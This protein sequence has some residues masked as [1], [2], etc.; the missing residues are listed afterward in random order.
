[1]RWFPFLVVSFYP[2]VYFT[3]TT[4]HSL[5]EP[6]SSALNPVWLMSAAPAGQ[7]SLST[8]GRGSVHTAYWKLFSTDQRFGPQGH[9]AGGAV[10]KGVR[11]S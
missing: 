5:D 8:K 3:L 10:R 4:C 11:P 7:L 6:L 9:P 2:S 1:M